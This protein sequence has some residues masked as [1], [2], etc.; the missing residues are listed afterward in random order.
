MQSGPLNPKAPGGA[1][2]RRACQRP[3][4]CPPTGCY[5][6]RVSSL[7]PAPAGVAH[8]PP[9]LGPPDG[10]A[11]AGWKLRLCLKP[12]GGAQPGFTPRL[13]GRRGPSHPALSPFSPP[14]VTT[15]DPGLTTSFGRRAGK[16]SHGLCG[17]WDGV[18]GGTG[19]GGT[20]M[21]GRWRWGA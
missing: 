16:S 17:G 19:S 7:P 11:T 1:P 21:G 5:P 4:V 6:Y 14:G 10:P 18:G 13:T 9:V 2:L 12:G 20:D 8:R 15:A 3:A